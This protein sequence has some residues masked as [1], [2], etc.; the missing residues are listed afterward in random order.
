METSIKTQ[1]VP[2][3]YNELFAQGDEARKAF[4]DRN[5]HNL[6][7]YSILMLR[8]QYR[9]GGTIHKEVSVRITDKD[10]I[11]IYYELADRNGSS[12]YTI[13]TTSWGALTL[14]EI[15]PYMQAYQR[16]I[17][18][19]KWMEAFDWETADILLDDVEL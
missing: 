10:A 1:K 9:K 15:E 6:N 12:K 4:F 5:R 16:A 18:T 19:V 7:G 11:Q 13:Q 8:K 2:Q 14:D 3:S 17:D